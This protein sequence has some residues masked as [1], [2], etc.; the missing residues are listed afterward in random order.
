[1][2]FINETA[3]LLNLDNQ[4][5]QTFCYVSPSNGIVVEGYKKIYELSNTKITLLCDKASKIDL[6]GE[7]LQIKEI[8]H[9]EIAITGHI[10]NINFT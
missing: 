8:S 2:G 9:S 5:K 7:N 4:T 1:M 6:H 3:K 10:K